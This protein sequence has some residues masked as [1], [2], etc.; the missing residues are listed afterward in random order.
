MGRKGEV[1]KEREETMNIKK[2]GGGSERKRG[3]NEHR[4][5]RER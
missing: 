2:K 1:V 4:E 3:D 5:E